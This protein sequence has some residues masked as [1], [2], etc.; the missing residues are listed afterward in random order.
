MLLALV[1]VAVAMPAGVASAGDSTGDTYERFAKVRERLIGC[2]LDDNWQH[3]SASGKRTCRRLR[4]LYTL[5]SD[6]NQGGTSYHVHCRT[7]KCFAAPSGYPDPR[8]PIPS[9]ALVYR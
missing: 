8:D 3:M 9:G 2:V 5:W 6:P 1:A 4:Q 7:S